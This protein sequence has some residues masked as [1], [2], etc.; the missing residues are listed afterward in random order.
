MRIARRFLISVSGLL[1]AAACA[2]VRSQDS[3]VQSTGA[4][5]FLG[6]WDLTL[7]APDREYPSWIEI[8]QKDGK[9]SA[10]FTSRWGNA[11]PLPK[12]EIDGNKVTFV[13][14]KEEEDRKEDMVFTGTLSGMKLT[15][16]TTGQDGTPWTWTGVRAPSLKRAKPPE[17]GEPVALFDGKD[18]AGWHEQG[19]GQTH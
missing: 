15:G 13:S 14:P 2:P 4:K 7:K 12:I 17:W 5:A 9:V 11:R 16:A 6:R 1:L 18:L 19:A 10:R 8:S 3:A